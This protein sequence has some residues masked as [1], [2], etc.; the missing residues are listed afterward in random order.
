MNTTTVDRRDAAKR[1]ARQQF[2]RW[3]LSYDRSWLNELIFFPCVRACQEEILRWQQPRGRAPFAVLD[4]GCGTGTLLSLLSRDPRAERLVGLDYSGEMARRAAAKFAAGDAAGR[5]TAV[6]GDAEHLPFH[7]GSFDILTCC[8]S[9]HHYPHP[10]AALA[11]FRR[12]LRPGGRLLLLDGFRDNLLGW[13]IFDVCVTTVEGHVRHQPWAAV[14]RLILSA[15]FG[16]VRQR[17]MNVLAP[18]LVNVA[19]Y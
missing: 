17:K 1:Q 6:Q 9:F 11:E 8:N 19:E 2:E 18:V 3:A 10:A 15:G 7:D 13:L 14:R 5:L 12:V 4:V 16:A